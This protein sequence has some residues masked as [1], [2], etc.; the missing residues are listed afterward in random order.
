MLGW[1]ADP[2]KLSKEIFRTD[3]EVFTKGPTSVIGG[4][5][6]IALRGKDMILYVATTGTPYLLRIDP[7]KPEPTVKEGIDFLDYNAPLEVAPPADAV[8]DLAEL[9]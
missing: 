4:R 1:F 2:R 9:T 5:P 7:L 6:A 3:G 8:E